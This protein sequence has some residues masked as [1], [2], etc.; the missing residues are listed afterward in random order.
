MPGTAGHR[1]FGYTRRLPSK[2]WQASYVGPDLSR[3]TA[4]LTFDAKD[5]AIAWLRGERK[6]ID[7]GEWMSYVDRHAAELANT[8]T[9]SGY[10]ADWLANRPLKP[11]TLEHYRR[12][13]ERFVDPRLG[14][15]QMR[16]LTP[17]VIRSWYSQLDASRPTQRAQTY[18]LLKAICKTAVDDDLFLANPC[19]IAGAG[20]TKRVSRTVPASIDE[21]DTLVAALPERYRAMGL[22]ASWCALRFGEVAE[23]RRSDIDLANGIVR[24]RRAVTWV[25]GTPIVGTPKSE[26]GLRDVAIPPHVLPGVRDHIRAMPMTGRDALLFPASRDTS[27]HLRPA[28]LY[29]VFYRAREKAGRPDLRFHDLRHTGAVYATQ[30]GASLAEV[31]A[32]LGHSTPAAAMRYQHAARGRDAEIARNL[33]AMTEVTQWR[34]F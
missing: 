11:R 18:A 31:M 28:S 6:L 15:L 29:R 25:R 12:L 5:D 33:S 26:A 4:P 13:L 9:V 3:H 24:V 21:L 7:A 17:P 2:R 30:A 1:G 8:V 20:Q 10:A 16:T 32:R 22:L 27:Q 34:P 23:L 19:R 14:H